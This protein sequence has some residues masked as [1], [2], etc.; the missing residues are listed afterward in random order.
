M[1]LL[2]G[3]WPNYKVRGDLHSRHCWLLWAIERP[4]HTHPHH[5]RLRGQFGSL[6]IQL[7]NLVSLTDWHV[8]SNF[9]PD[10]HHPVLFVLGLADVY[11]NNTSASVECQL[12]WYKMNAAKPLVWQRNWAE[13]AEKDA[14][15]SLLFCVFR[16]WHPSL[17]GY[18]LQALKLSSE[19]RSALRKVYL[20]YAS[21]FT[22]TVS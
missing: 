1:L 10:E 12:K 15:F 17:T 22:R 20:F 9:S 16:Q 11:K 18:H 14:F 8:I 2:V 19:S 21:F 13:Q 3:C 7:Q 4:G 5:L 6:H